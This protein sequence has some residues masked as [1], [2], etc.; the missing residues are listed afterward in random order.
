MTGTDTRVKDIRCQR[1]DGLAWVLP[2]LSIV[3]DIPIGLGKRGL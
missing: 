1:Y 2:E 3:R